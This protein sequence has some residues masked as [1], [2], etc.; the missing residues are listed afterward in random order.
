MKHFIVCNNVAYSESKGSR[1]RENDMENCYQ[2]SIMKT[3]DIST[4]NPQYFSETDGYCFAKPITMVDNHNRK[5][6]HSAH[7]IIKHSNKTPLDNNSTNNIYLDFPSEPFKHEYPAVGIES[8]SNH[9][10]DR[11]IDTYDTAQNQVRPTAIKT[12]DANLNYNRVGG[13]YNTSHQQNRL[14]LT[15]Q[16]S[17]VNLYDLRVSGTYDNSQLQFF[18]NAREGAG[19]VNP[20]DFRISGT[21]DTSQNIVGDRIKYEDESAD[22]YDH[23]CGQKDDGDYDHVTK[24]RDDIGKDANIYEDN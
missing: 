8:D 3:K 5:T 21:Y 15:N 16:D 24:C 9:Y 4:T 2:D 23:F 14:K 19:D 7:K 17:N 13:T 20:Y 10:D 12:D 22:A 11:S 6:N 1:P 18:P